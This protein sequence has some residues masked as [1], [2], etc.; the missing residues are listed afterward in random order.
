MDIYTPQCAQA[1]LNGPVYLDRRSTWYLNVAGR[2]PGGVSEAQLQ[3]RLRAAS[4]PIFAATLPERWGASD[5][6][7]YLKTTLTLSPAAT[8]FS[9]TRDR[10]RGA[11][12]TLMAVVGVVLLIAC[13]NIAN[14]LLARAAAREREIA[15]RLAIGAGRGRVVRQLLTESLVLASAGAVLGLVFAQWAGGLL[16][17]F[18]SSAKRPL[19]L[20]LSLDWRVVAFTTGVAVLTAVLFGL[21]PAWR[22]TRV[23]PQAALKAGG[24][25]LVGGR[26]RHRL[27]KALVVAQVALSLTLVA[28]AGLLVN[29]FR[30]LT[31]FDPGFRRAGVLVTHFELRNTGLKDAALDEAKNEILRGA[32]LLPGVTS[33]SLSLLTPIGNMQWDEFVVVPGVTPH[34]HKD[35]VVYFNSV[36]DGYFTTLG[37]PFVAGRDITPDDIAQ[38]RRVAV[39]N[40]SM[41]KY[42]FGGTNPLGRSFRTAFSDS[43][44]P[45]IEVVGVVRDT[46]Y[47]RI[48]ETPLAIAYLPIGQAEATGPFIELVMRTAG[49]PRR[50]YARRAKTR[51]ERKPEGLARFHDARGASRCVTRAPAPARLAVGLHGRAGAPARGDRVVWH[52]VVRCE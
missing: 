2:L 31:Q 27:G 17:G 23:D 35:S 7:E 11:L 32:R 36:A 22:A 48:D 3:T 9:E 28:A 29:S 5:Q 20:D 50:T 25:G 42:W 37:T 41:A 16:V 44:S 1:V 26:S 14:L 46:K 51:G 33:A 47:A 52:D 45:P 6:K 18:M 4:P 24:R 38:K 13:A 34:S 40:E 43:V 12:F 8:G 19:W 21:V 10:Y 30:R 15:I 49:D 39:V